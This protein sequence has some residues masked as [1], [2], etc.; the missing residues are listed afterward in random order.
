MGYTYNTVSYHYNANGFSESNDYLGG[1]LYTAWLPVNGLLVTGYV[2]YLPNLSGTSTISYGSTTLYHG[3][4]GANGLLQLGVQADYRLTGPVYAFYG[5][6]Y[7]L[8]QYYR[9][10]TNTLKADV[11]ISYHF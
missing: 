11:G 5:V 4:D 3:Y 10:S 6:Q 7:D 1:G 8:S 2:G 9:L